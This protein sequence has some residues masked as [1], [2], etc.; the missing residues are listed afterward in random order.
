MTSLKSY[1]LNKEFLEKKG[2]LYNEYEGQAFRPLTFAER[3][4]NWVWL[5]GKIKTLGTELQSKISHYIPKIAQESFT[6]KDFNALISDVSDIQKKGF[7]YW[8]QTTSSEMSVKVKPTNQK[9][10]DAMEKA[11]EVI[12]GKIIHDIDKKLWRFTEEGLISQFFNW[13]NTLFVNGSIN[14]GRETVYEN[15]KELIYAFEYSAILDGRATEIC[16]T[17][18][19]TVV[20]PD[21]QRAETLSPP[22]HWGCRSIR[23]EILDEEVYKPKISV[24]IPK[25]DLGS[26]IDFAWYLKTIAQKT[27]EENLTKD[28][29]QE[30][31]K[32]LEKQI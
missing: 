22:N 3:K 26:K 14:L 30:E 6:L 31:L 24:S 21:S 25:V 23:V 17:L 4:V 15:N 20:K 28:Q 1:S 19:W 18:D 29:V 27:L 5:R 7:D 10:Y 8:K 12:V 32:R 11:N 16:R 13:M 9:V 2:F